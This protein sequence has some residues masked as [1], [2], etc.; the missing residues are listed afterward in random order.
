[1]GNEIERPSLLIADKFRHSTSTLFALLEMSQEKLEL[2]YRHMGH[3][4]QMNREVYQCPLAIK[5]ITEVGSFLQELDTKTSQRR[6]HTASKKDCEITNRNHQVIAI[7]SIEETENTSNIDLEQNHLKVTATNMESFE[8]PDET[9]QKDNSL[10]IEVP[11]MTEACQPSKKSCCRRSY[12]NDVNDSTTFKG[13]LPSKKEVEI[14]IKD[15][16][17]FDDQ[18][19]THSTLVSLIKFL[20]KEKG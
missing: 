19:I 17:I 4:E 8:N 13:S 5:E 6:V 20:M 12:I 11:E 9:V 10:L 15:F 14:F 7:D 16:H 1:M 3:S 18:D 2:F